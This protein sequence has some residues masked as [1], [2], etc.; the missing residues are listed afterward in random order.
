MPLRAWCGSLAAGPA[1]TQRAVCGAYILSQA[2]EGWSALPDVY[3][4]GGLSGGTLERSA[5]LRRLPD[6]AARRVNI[7]VVYKVDHGSRSV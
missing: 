6:V 5:L 1:G 7:I 4:D 3:G 2:S